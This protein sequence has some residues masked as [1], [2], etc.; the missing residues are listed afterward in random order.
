[1]VHGDIL[2]RVK[3]FKY[4]RRLLAQDND[5]IQAVH[6]QICKAKGIWACIGQVL[7][8]GNASPHVADKFYKA[9]VQSVLLYGS[10]MW[11]L[12]KAVLVRLVGFHILTTYR[13][14]QKHKP[15]KGLFR[16]WEYPSTKNVLE[17]CGLHSVKD[18][19]DTA[20]IALQYML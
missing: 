5:H 9:V 1:M 10:K 19:I 14:V 13:M 8:G 20:I 11:N 6:Q 18:C 4:L 3:V 15:Y 7:Q 12:T 16:K 17:E 2:E